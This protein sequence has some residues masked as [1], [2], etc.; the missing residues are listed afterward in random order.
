MNS[1]RSM[2]VV[3]LI[4]MTIVSFSNLVGVNIAGL[5][6]IL[7]ITFFFIHRRFGKRDTD[8]LDIKAIRTYLKQKA[9]WFWIALPLVMNIIC[10]ALAALSYQNSL[11]IFIIEHSL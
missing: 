2:V 7:G 9:I 3:G 6:V 5:S 10:F 8:G 1:N 4:L 11:T